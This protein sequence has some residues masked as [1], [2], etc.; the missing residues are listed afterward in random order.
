[1]PYNIDSFQ[2]VNATIVVNDNTIDSTSLSI[3]LI[4]KKISGYGEI[5]AENFYHI[6]ESFAG[7]NPP[8]NPVVGQVW[9]DTNTNSLKVF[10]G[11]NPAIDWIGVSNSDVSFGTVLP[12][13]TG[14]DDGTLFFKQDNVSSSSGEL[15]IKIGTNWFQLTRLFAQQPST[16]SNPEDGYIW[17]KTDTKELFIRLSGGWTPLVTNKASTIGSKSQWGIFKTNTPSNYE[18]A[19]VEVCGKIVASFSDNEI[20]NAQA[21]SLNYE[22]KNGN[23][24]TLSTPFPQGISKGFTLADISDTIRFSTSASIKS[25]ENIKID[26]DNANIVIISA[27][28]TTITNPVEFNNTSYVKLP[29]GSNS[30]RPSNPKI[31]YI[32]YNEDIDNI[33]Y[34]VSSPATWVSLL[35]QS[36]LTIVNNVNDISI[37]PLPAT[38][39]SNGIVAS[40]NLPTNSIFYNAFLRD[41]ITGTKIP[42]NNV[43][44][45]R[46][47]TRLDS[48]TINTNNDPAY[49]FTSEHI[50][51]EPN[52]DSNVFRLKMSRVVQSITTSTN[53][54][55]ITPSS[56]STLTNAVI[57]LTN[58]NNI[59]ERSLSDFDLIIQYIN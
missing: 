57:V 3:K 32:R 42:M 8:N 23:T 30:N 29:V 59:I 27:S 47:P 6:L 13:V 54:I 55:Q 12:A 14:I 35:S 1:M 48:I 58:N 45:Y 36:N 44:T 26:V 15:Y 10:K 31:G 20:T 33:E 9:F 5:I 37:G 46:S 11:G 49:K 28:K 16:P 39:P 50:T 2:G 34:Y 41:T 43:Y 18:L 56:N 17:S 25:L 40:A 22:L 53:P 4:G 7:P 38:I 51:I 19:I 21:G 52:L 24:I